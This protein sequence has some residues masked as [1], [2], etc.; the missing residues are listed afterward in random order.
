MASRRIEDLQP[1]LQVKARYHLNLCAAADIDLLIYCTLRTA[2][3]QA[4]L[5][6]RGRTKPGRI[7]T[8]A[9]P[10]SSAHNFGLAYDC[11]PLRGGKAV[12]GAKGADLDLWWHVGRIGKSL[13]LEWAGDWTKFKEFPHFQ[14]PQWRSFV[15]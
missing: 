7:V 12:W 10:G 2:A 13:G 3:E 1:L 9:K 8:Y 6:A 4:E 14:I 11:V 15:Q 5:Y